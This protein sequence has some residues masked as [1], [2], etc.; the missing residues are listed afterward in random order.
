VTDGGDSLHTQEDGCGALT[1]WTWTDATSAD[2]AIAD[3][4]L[5]TIIKAGCV[6]RAI[7]SAG[8][9]KISCQGQGVEG[10]LRRRSDE[11]RHSSPGPR[12]LTEEE[13]LTLVH[14][15][16]NHSMEHNTYTPMDWGVTSTAMVTAP[17]TLA[18]LGR[19]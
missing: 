1:F 9:P 6:E 8:G 5:P 14:L 13:K 19:F 10:G 16:G 11:T 17:A 12:V 3:F 18:S 2:G 7:V 4:D 15:Y